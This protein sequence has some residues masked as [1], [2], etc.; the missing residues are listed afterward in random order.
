MLEHLFYKVE[1][2]RGPVLLLSCAGL[3][4]HP[5]RHSSS[6][7]QATAKQNKKMSSPS[8]GRC[9]DGCKRVLP[10]KK[11]MQDGHQ[12]LGLEQALVPTTSLG[13]ALTFAVP[14]H[15]RVLPG[16]GAAGGMLQHDRA[17]ACYWI[18]SRTGFSSGGRDAQLH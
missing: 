14:K 12:L 1:C 18:I 4:L 9:N 5:S 6:I 11:S 2:S 7:G 15:G 3:R 17:F 16:G 8:K 10:L 13:C